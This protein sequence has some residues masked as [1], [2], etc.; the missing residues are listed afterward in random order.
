MV[1]A[2]QQRRASGGLL[3]NL[4]AAVPAHVM[5]REYFCIRGSHHDDRGTERLDDDIVALL[6]DLGDVPHHDPMGAQESLDFEAEQLGV[7]IERL[8]KAAAAP[9]IAHQLL[10]LRRSTHALYP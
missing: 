4:R 6:R 8:G 9:M 1:A 10:Q 7:L 3:A 2:A 5:Q